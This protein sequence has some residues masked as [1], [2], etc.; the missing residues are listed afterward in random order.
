MPLEDNQYYLRNVFVQLS[1]HFWS[2]VYKISRAEFTYD[3]S[4]NLRFLYCPSYADKLLSKLDVT[5]LCVP[6]CTAISGN[7]GK[8]LKK[9]GK[10]YKI[11]P[12]KQCSPH[13]NQMGNVWVARCHI[14]AK[15]SYLW[16]S[17]LNFKLFQMKMSGNAQI[18]LIKKPSTANTADNRCIKSLMVKNFV[19]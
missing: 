4:N 12:E 6:Y 5:S 3:V 1:F 14:L 10:Q 17:L 13:F 8:S 19:P 18:T 7:T 11:I 9:Y 15:K 16:L 2:T